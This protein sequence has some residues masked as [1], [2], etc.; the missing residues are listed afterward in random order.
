MKRTHAMP[1]TDGTC[2]SASSGVLTLSRVLKN[3]ESVLIHGAVLS[4]LLKPGA[5]LAEGSSM[6]ESLPRTS[7]EVLGNTSG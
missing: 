2:R 4:V 6:P 5:T 1:L 7:I 3:F